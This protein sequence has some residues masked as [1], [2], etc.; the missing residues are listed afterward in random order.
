M[1]ENQ[2]PVIYTRSNPN[3]IFYTSSEPLVFSVKGL[4]TKNVFPLSAFDPGHKNRCAVKKV[5]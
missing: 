1:F 4:I 2:M 3:C 5:A